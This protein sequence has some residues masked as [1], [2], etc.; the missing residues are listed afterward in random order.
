MKK[1]T[2]Q[3]ES[4]LVEHAAEGNIKKLVRLFNETFCTNFSYA[5]VQWKRYTLGI[6]TRECRARVRWRP[7]GSE[8]I[9]KGY[10]RIKVAEPN[11]WEQKQV[12]IYK[13]AHPEEVFEKYDSVVFLD[14]NNRNFKIENLFKLSKREIGVLNVAFGGIKKG[15]DPQE[16][17]N[18]ILQLRLKMTVLDKA[19]PL[20]LVR[21]LGKKGGRRLKSEEAEMAKKWKEKS[22]ERYKAA[23]KKYAE[24]HRQRMKTDPVYAAEFRRKQR[25]YRRERR[26]RK[27][28]KIR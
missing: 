28:G 22:P 15:S 25:E 19:E 26:Q 14:G 16:S 21:Y 3:Q 6:K 5:S 4:F 10:V 12:W 9:K 27:G 11:V 8:C 20:G 13:Q 7:V 23:Y 17:L 18:R 1:W 24:K 2:A